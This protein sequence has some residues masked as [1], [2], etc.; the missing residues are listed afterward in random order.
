MKGAISNSTIDDN[1]S[2]K[3]YTGARVQA[4]QGSVAETY[5]VQDAN[6]VLN[7]DTWTK[8]GLQRV[9]PDAI[10]KSPIKIQAPV[11][12]SRPSTRQ[13]AT[14]RLAQPRRSDRLAG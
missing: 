10:E 11:R 13:Q 2:R 8:T 6:G 3:L 12:Q 4:G 7:K 1:W 14:V 5:R 9:N